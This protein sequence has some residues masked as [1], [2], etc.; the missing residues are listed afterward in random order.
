M[1]IDHIENEAL[2]TN[3]IENNFSVCADVLLTFL[4]Q[5]QLMTI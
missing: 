5:K 1:G 2:K 4:A 3:I